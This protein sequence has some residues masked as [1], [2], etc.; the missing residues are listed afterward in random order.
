MH[1]YEVLLPAAH[2]SCVLQR[3]GILL[4]AS[5]HTVTAHAKAEVIA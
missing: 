3:L 5:L 1:L 4:Q 2:L